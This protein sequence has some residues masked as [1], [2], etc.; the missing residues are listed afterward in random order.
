MN[1]Y[2]KMNIKIIAK[3]LPK[4]E[5]MTQ[6]TSIDLIDTN[7]TCFLYRNIPY[8]EYLEKLSPAHCKI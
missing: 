3:V 6:I 2:F 7:T 5:H 4:V 1:K 8:M